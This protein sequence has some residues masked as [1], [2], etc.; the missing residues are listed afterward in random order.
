MPYGL[1]Y[2]MNKLLCLCG[3]L[4][5]CCGFAFAQLR[6]ITGIVYLDAQRQSDVIIRNTGSRAQTISNDIGEF[7]IRAKT[8]DTL[9]VIKN[10]LPNDSLLVTDQPSLIVNL[11]REPT[12]LK[13]VTINSTALT[14]EKV[15]ENNKKDYHEIY[16]IG[17]KRHAVIITPFGPGILIDKLWSAVSREGHNARKLQKQFTID[18]KNAIIDHRFN[19]TLVAKITGYKDKKLETFMDRY[20]PTFEFADKA[21][22]YEMIDYIRTGMAS[23]KKERKT[24]T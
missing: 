13:E 19:K 2:Q 18:Y 11:K 8:G 12:M 23:D 4:N 7:I 15:L 22:D 6:S 5:F 14:P 3:L 10:N 17:D 24:N 16:R 9:V 1:L 20:R 21:T